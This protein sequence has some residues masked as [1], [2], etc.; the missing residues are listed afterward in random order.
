[1]GL[2][3]KALQF[4]NELNN[5]GKETLIDKIIGPA[6]TGMLKDTASEIKE[7]RIDGETRPDRGDTQ[8]ADGEPIVYLDDEEL[9]EVDRKSRAFDED[10]GL[11]AEEISAGT[12]KNAIAERKTPESDE[13]DYDI[14]DIDI[15]ETDR[16]DV[17][18]PKSPKLRGEFSGGETDASDE[19]LFKGIFSDYMTLVENYRE[20]SKT[21]TIESFFEALSF[22]IMGQ[23]GVSSSSLLL[24]DM[25]N[26]DKWRIAES[27]GI[28]IEEADLDF[29]I[30]SGILAKV[31]HHREIIDID[32]FKDDETLTDDFYKYISIDARLLIPLVYREELA[33][34]VT[35]GDKIT[36]ELY[37]DEEKD[38]LYALGDFAASR[39]CSILQLNRNARE[40]DSLEKTIN[41][42]RDLE[43][44]YENI[45][46][47]PDEENIKQVIRSEL[48]SLGVE[49]FGIFMRSPNF[50]RYL[51]VI[52]EREDYL[53]YGELDFSIKSKS[54]FLSF[55]Q[56]GESPLLI[57]DI[58]HSRILSE[59]FNENQMSHFS[60][61]RLYPFRL[62]GEIP[63]FIMV[64]RVADMQRIHE[65]DFKMK[66]LSS[67][68][69]PLMISI[70]NQSIKSRK[71]IDNVEVI[72]KKIDD[73]IINARNLGIPL[74]LILFSIKNYKRYYNLYGVDEA[75]KLLEQF[76]KTVRIRLSDGD[77]CVRYDRH[78]VLLVLPGKDKKFAVPL[79]NAIRNEIVQGFRKKEIQ[80]LLTFLTAEF[81]D[82][83]NN[84]YSLMDAID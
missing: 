30:Y 29:S 81:P 68:I 62:G 45:G 36:S 33:G 37:S 38:Y 43:N 60:I 19:S 14:P 13:R 54:H 58:A 59:A 57:E 74:T 24:Q 65:I 31:D 66:R 32:S 4:K 78:K 63:G 41:Y 6:E 21:E 10:S 22:I 5:R 51:P 47:R 56:E 18:I 76:E 55:M 26:P 11:L 15:D 70:E 67:H 40:N 16:E 53:L 84:V 75:K 80:L 7:N 49:C 8:N 48:R 3:E 17:I 42:A 64:N 28:T 83:G 27:R 73:E 35:I 50:D 82:D 61:A 9:K 12:K 71:Y 20:L 1:M 25:D 2:L 46:V 72:Y 79:A 69:F 44:I 34:V 52:Y 39:L 77:F 23:I